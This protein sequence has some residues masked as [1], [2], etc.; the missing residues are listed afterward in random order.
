MQECREQRHR[1]LFFHVYEHGELIID[2]E[3]SYGRDIEEALNEAKAS[4]QDLASR[5]WHVTNHPT[6]CA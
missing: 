2:E 4:A 6:N 3:G 1:S 5:H